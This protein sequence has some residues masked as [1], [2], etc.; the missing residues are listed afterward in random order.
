MTAEAGRAIVL[1]GFMGAGKS[2]ALRSLG[3]GGLDTDRLIEQ[4][5]GA[6]IPAIFE[7]EG[8]AA[9]REIEE[10]VALDAVQRASRGEAGGIVALGGG[11]LAS[12]RLRSEL[13]NHTVV[14]LDADVDTCWRRVKGSSRPLA[15]EPESFRRLYAERSATYSDVA[16]AI[17]PGQGGQSF[18]AAL[19]WIRMLGTL[20]FR[21]MLVWAEASSGA[22][23]VFIGDGLLSAA[24]VRP[25]GRAALVTDSNVAR[26]HGDG[27]DPLLA[28]VVIEPGEEAKNLASC[29]AVWEQLAAAGL[30]RDDQLF[31][32]GG[33]VV[34]DLAGFVAA[35]YQ[36]GIPVVH[37]PTTLVAQVDSSIGG[38][39][40]VDLP[41]GKNYV[42]A[43]HQPR[44]VIADTATLSTLP[45]EEF[46]AGMAEVIKTALIAGGPL[47]EIVARGGAADERVV[48]ECVRTK[49]AIVSADERDGGLRQ[50]LN[51]GHTVAH[52]I[53][54][55]TGYSR[56][57][58]GEAVALGLMVALRLSGADSLRDEV[59]GLL[60]GAD[61][62][63]SC[64][65]VDAEQ[66]V[67]ATRADKKARA[68]GRIPFVLCEEPGKVSHGNEIEH[69]A[70]V[71]AVGEVCR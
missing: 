71:S 64:E 31:A 32:V 39:T 34:G 25:D 24:S 17:V 3:D 5:A 67:S 53:E 70:L 16:D 12:T 49:A 27:F 19:P 20:P 52:A 60:A 35:S 65:G 2:T 14:M 62:P 43:Y 48:R 38:K 28:T 6:A 47:W 40:G 63:T 1:V 4:E 68:D 57:R 33:G 66:V 11:A 10:R 21:A 37:F 54:T 51:L 15:S 26:L 22:Y 44:A 58:H 55:V 46:A 7:R 23:P 45:A 69:A 50:L 41:Q 13:A 8:E 30:T 29:S 56:F 36:R 9:F 42:G 18:R 61:L 59:G